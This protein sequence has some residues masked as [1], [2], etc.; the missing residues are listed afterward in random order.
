MRIASSFDSEPPDVNI[1]RVMPSGASA[2][3]R[4]ANSSWRSVEAQAL[5]M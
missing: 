4:P 5:W 1:A 3:S 2:V